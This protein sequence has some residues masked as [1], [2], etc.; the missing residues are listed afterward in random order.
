MQ[1]VF[2]F[3]PQRNIRKETTPGPRL[4][5]R[6][7]GGILNDSVRWWTYNQVADIAATCHTLRC[8]S[9]SGFGHRAQECVSKRIQP[10]NIPSHT[11]V[12]TTNEL[13]KTNT[14]IFEDQETKA[15]LKL[16]PFSPNFLNFWAPPH[17]FCICLI[18]WILGFLGHA[19]IVDDFLEFTVR[20]GFLKDSCVWDLWWVA[21]FKVDFS[22]SIGSN[23]LC[24]GSLLRR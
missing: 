10:R 5:G 19:L 23:I 11:S 9:W 24:C 21:D 20:L 15:L 22:L 14:G 16:Q 6:R 12:I 2:I 13:W 8:Y 7:S 17:G 1:Q 18:I 3:I 4:Y